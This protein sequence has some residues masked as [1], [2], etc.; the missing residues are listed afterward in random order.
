MTLMALMTL[1]L[2]AS[3]TIDSRRRGRRASPLARSDVSRALLL[4]RGVARPR[5][6]TAGPKAE[7]VLPVVDGDVPIGLT[8]DDAAELAGLRASATAADT[9]AADAAEM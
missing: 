4:L 8:A 1:P 6:W 3:A 7:D 2:H 5:W 9:K